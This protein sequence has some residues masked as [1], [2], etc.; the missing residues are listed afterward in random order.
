MISHRRKDTQEGSVSLSEEKSDRANIDEK[1]NFN[2][3]EEGSSEESGSS[4]SSSSDRWKN[5]RYQK[6]R[7]RNSSGGKRNDGDGRSSSSSSVSNNDP[8]DDEFR[9]YLESLSEKEKNYKEIRYVLE[10]YR[11]DD[12]CKKLYE[13][14]RDKYFV[15]KGKLK[16]KKEILGKKTNLKKDELLH[17]CNI[18]KNSGQN[19]IRNCLRDCLSTKDKFTFTIKVI[20]INKQE[21]TNNEGNILHN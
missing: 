20:I 3:R 15:W 2:R 18:P 17:V 21:T 1:W 12:Y 4:E 13:W 7:E 14:N 10:H 11:T 9:E 16:L 19:E 8:D 5:N 6:R